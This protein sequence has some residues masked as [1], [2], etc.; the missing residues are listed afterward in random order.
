[1]NTE[2]SCFKAWKIHFYS[3]KFASKFGFG[4]TLLEILRY[5]FFHYIGWVNKK[6]YLNFE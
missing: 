4:Y 5:F 6:V 3:L 2:E 1:M